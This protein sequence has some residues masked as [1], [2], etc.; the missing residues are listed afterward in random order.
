MRWKKK[1][2]KE[3][4]VERKAVRKTGEDEEGRQEEQKEKISLGN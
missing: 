3:E 1:G 4:S 2:R